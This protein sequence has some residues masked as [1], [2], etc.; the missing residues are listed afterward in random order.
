MYPSANI[1]VIHPLFFYLLRNISC[2]REFSRY[3]YL[4]LDRGI[5]VKLLKWNEYIQ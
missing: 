2:L 1:G 4:R 5:S 3:S